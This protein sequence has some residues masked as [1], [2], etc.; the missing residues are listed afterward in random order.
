MIGDSR[1]SARKLLKSSVKIRT[2][3]EKLTSSKNFE[4]LLEFT[5]KPKKVTGSLW[6][7]ENLLARDLG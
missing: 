4:K 3:S 5:E 7:F 2:T 6:K 1:E